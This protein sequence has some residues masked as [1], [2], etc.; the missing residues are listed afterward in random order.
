[1][2][3]CLGGDLRYSSQQEP[4]RHVMPGSLVVKRMM[5]TGRPVSVERE[6]HAD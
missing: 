5:W 4:N 3:Q 6:K 1:M 2:T